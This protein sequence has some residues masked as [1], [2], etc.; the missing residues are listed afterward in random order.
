MR[1]IAALA[2]C[3]LL[4]A[5]A[6]AAPTCTEAAPGVAWD[7]GWLN[8]TA[9]VLAGLDAPLQSQLGERLQPEMLARHRQTLGAGWAQ[10]RSRQLDAVAA[11]GA[12]ELRIDGR[13]IERVYYPFSG[14][15]ALYL[16]AL[17]PDA[18]AALMTG[19]EP[20]GTVPVLDSLSAAEIDASLA[21]LRRSLHAVLSFSFFRTNDLSVD[22]SRNRF[23]GVTPILF[24]FLAEAGYA[25]F[26]VS[27]LLLGMDGQVCV[28]D[29]EQVGR[30]P[31]GSL[32]GVRIDY[33]RPG[34][35]EFRSLEY[36]Q[37]DIGDGGLRRTPQYLEHLSAFAPQASYIKSASYL[38]HK[39]YFSLVRQAILDH[40]Q[41]VL[42]DDSGIPHAWFRPAHWQ[43]SLYGRYSAPIALFAN[44]LQPE[45]QRAYA[46]GPSE[47]L[48]FGIGYRHRR[49][50]S[51]LQIYRRLPADPSGAGLPARP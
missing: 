49:N 43:P 50:D 4:P 19:L 39:S 17:F 40:S 38:M 20:V 34:E 36:W 47:A 29:A 42:Q 22:L 8:D 28:A 2:L 15:D 51:N 6:P 12:R 10:L 46:R 18:R 26:D 5:V 7:Q 32:A 31:R 25:I 45:L 1:L 33:F 48:D 16:L 11:F 44:W 27:Y 3:L 21:E 9:R 37:A 13:P 35:M 23:H 24:V 41:L 30:P 14:P